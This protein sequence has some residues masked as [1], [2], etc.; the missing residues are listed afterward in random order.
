MAGSRLT[1]WHIVTGE[2]PPQP[3]GVADYTAQLAEALRVAGQPVRVWCH[4]FGGFTPA[5]LARVG[6]ELDSCP[7]PR[8]ILLQWVPHSYGRHSMNV[9]FCRWL[10]ARPEPLE[11]MV[12]EPGLGFGEGGLRHSAVAAV[13]RLMTIILLRRAERVWISI[14]A[15]EARLRPYALGRKIPFTWLPVPSNI[16]VSTTYAPRVHPLGYFGQYDDSTR[17]VLH[18]VLDQLD[19]PV[20]LLGR[21]S[22]RV[23]HKNAQAAGELSP[24]ALSQA[25]QSCETIFHLYPDGVSTRRGTVMASLA[26]GMAIV[27]NTGKFTE[28]L[29]RESGAVELGS[30]ATGITLQLKRL[31][32]DQALRGR[33]QTKALNLYNERFAISKTIQSLIGTA[34]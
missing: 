26:H 9:N 15:W 23:T 3:G 24:A 32:A 25:I 34:R 17:E 18:Q 31:I 27:T 12:H 4:E 20:L 28:P 6:R 10:A 13:H 30:D 1:T 19:S 11:I 14:P 2:Y 21:Q 29:W 16:P 22:H 5:G 7:A 33:L 8:R